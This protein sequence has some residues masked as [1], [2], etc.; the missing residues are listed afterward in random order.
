MLH[1]LVLLVQLAADDSLKPISVVE[2]VNHREKYAGKIVT[3][4]GALS[5]SEEFTAL[6]GEG[7]EPRLNMTRKP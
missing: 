1:I 2:A 7:C 3:A 4:T 5:A 6:S